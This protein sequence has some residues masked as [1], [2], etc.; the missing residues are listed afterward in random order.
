ML[1][2]NLTDQPSRASERSETGGVGLYLSQQAAEKL[3]GNIS[4]ETTPEKYTKFTAVIPADFQKVIDLRQAQT[5]EG[6]VRA[7]AGKNL[8]DTSRKAS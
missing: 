5:Q 8:P 2:Y 1:L 6:A 4:F 3:G 7:E